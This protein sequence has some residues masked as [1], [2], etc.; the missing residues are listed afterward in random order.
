MIGTQRVLTIQNKPGIWRHK[1]RLITFALVVDYFGKKILGK[2]C[3]P[4]DK[5]HTRSLSSINILGRTT[6]LS[7]THQME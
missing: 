7:H 6:I 2:T 4:L 5:C 3:R 1:W